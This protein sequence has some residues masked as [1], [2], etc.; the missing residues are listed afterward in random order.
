MNKINWDLLKQKLREDILV[1]PHFFKNPI[2]GM[3]SLPHWEWPTILVLQGAFAIACSTL[4]NLLERDILGLVTGILIAP[5][6]SYA[7]VAVGAGIFF[8]IFHFAFHRQI[9][10][11]QIYQHI[12]FA[13]IPI[14]ILSIVMF[15]LP[16][17]LLLGS[18]TSLFLLYVG[19]TDNLHIPAK[20]LRQILAV[21][22]AVHVFYWGF[23]QVQTSTKHKT[24]RQKATPESLDILEKELNRED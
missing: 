24:L 22:L 19:F 23:Q 1:L 2:Q 4:A 18:A 16:P 13:G 7:L 15:A 17:L 14:G 8:Y 21:F 6:M 11:R 9:P 10:Y 3:R 20:P 12:L 5:L